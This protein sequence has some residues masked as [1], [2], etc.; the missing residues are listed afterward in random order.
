MDCGQFDQ[1]VMDLLYGETSESSSV[2]AKRHVDQCER[3]AAVLADLRTAKSTLNLPMEQAPESIEPKVLEA[4]RQYQKEIPWPRRLGRWISWVGGYAMRPQL[5]MAALLLLMLGSSLLL[6]RA[7]PGAEQVDVVRVVEQGVPQPETLEGSHAIEP[8]QL[9]PSEDEPL[10]R[11]KDSRNGTV[12]PPDTARTKTSKAEA[13]A[14]STAPTSSTAPPAADGFSDAMAMYRA[15]DYANA[16]RA[17]DQVVLKGGPNAP[18]AALLAAKSVR[19]SSGC[20]H[21]LPRFESVSSRYAG[22]SEAI[23]ARWETASC[24]RI[25]GDLTRARLI[26]RD[27]AQIEGLRERAENELARISTGSTPPPI[28]PPSTPD[29]GRTDVPG[30]PTP[31]PSTSS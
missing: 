24:A 4:A 11:R 15:K 27:L 1:I 8:H 17:F 2:E 23:E 29:V 18:A 22:S 10:D 9:P 5:A 12:E 26:Y 20:A 31:P 28:P 21:A 14:P 7:R 3:C 19:A 16:Y 13:D 30:N 6:I 25:I